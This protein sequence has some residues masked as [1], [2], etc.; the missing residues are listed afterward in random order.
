MPMPSSFMHAFDVSTPA[1][2]T[3]ARNTINKLILKYPKTAIT[4]FAQVPMYDLPPVNDKNFQ[5]V[6]STW[7]L[8]MFT[9]DV[10]DFYEAARIGDI[11]VPI[12]GTK[13]FV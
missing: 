4:L 9:M 6:E 7:M 12:P 3:G 10:Q 8:I 13:Q 2:L 11:P 1:M 5:A